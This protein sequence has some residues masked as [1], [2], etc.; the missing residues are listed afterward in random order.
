MR[1]WTPTLTLALVLAAAG[2]VS[3]CGSGPSTPAAGQG[4]KIG[5][6]GGPALPLGES[7]FA[8]VVLDRSKVKPVTNDGARIQ[9]YFLDPGL[10]APLSPAPTEVTVK[11]EPPG[12]SPLTLTL[13]PEPGDKP[14]DKGRFV[15]PPGKLDYDELRGEV[16]ATVNGSAVTQPFALR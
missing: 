6:H 3:G 16:T 10:K 2:V 8:E 7:G 5:P 14:L 1:R 12:E 9:V 4:T 13:K 11:A 15:S